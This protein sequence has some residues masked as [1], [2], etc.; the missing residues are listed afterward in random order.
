MD[1]QQQEEVFEKLLQYNSK[2]LEEKD[3]LRK[4]KASKFSGFS[5]EEKKPQ[6]AFNNIEPSGH[7]GLVFNQDLLGLSFL[8]DL[9]KGLTSAGVVSDP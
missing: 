3:Q 4:M 5:Y 9:G 7:F 2:Y 8:Q 6:L 1:L